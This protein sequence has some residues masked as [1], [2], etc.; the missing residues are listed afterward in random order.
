MSVSFEFIAD[1]FPGLA[2][3]VGVFDGTGAAEDGPVEGEDAGSLEELRA[4]DC[5]VW[6]NG[7]YV[8]D[9]GLGP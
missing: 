5:C 3:G 9:R 4:L 7:G 8:R 1:E 6:G 2:F